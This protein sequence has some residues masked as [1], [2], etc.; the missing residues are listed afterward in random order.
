MVERWPHTLAYLKLF[1]KELKKRSGYKQY[2]NG[3]GPYWAIYNTGRETMSEWKVV[4][5]TMS[6]SLDAAVLGPR[7]DAAGK[8]SKACVF[9]NTMIFVPA[10]SEEEA[11]YLAALLN[12]TWLNY[13]IRASNVRGGKSSNATNVLTT[14][15]IPKF[16]PRRPVHR[17]L[18]ELA[19]R[20]AVE[21]EAND[22]AIV[23]TEQA[24]DDAA[25]KLW[26]VPKTAAA[27]MRE[28]LAVLG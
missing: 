18:A 17:R 12:S 21:K 8:G 22:E 27:V 16:N 9:K 4:W 23:L 5:R 19:K 20:A 24:I 25:A 3:I 6:A 14:V 15:G 11:A 10:E 26:S 13:V 28:A 7:P 2:F 1:E